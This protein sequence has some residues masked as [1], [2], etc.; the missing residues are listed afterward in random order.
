MDTDKIKIYGAR[1]RV[2]AIDKVSC[3]EEVGKVVMNWG[4]QHHVGRGGGLCFV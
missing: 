2:D 1:V 4:Y 3:V